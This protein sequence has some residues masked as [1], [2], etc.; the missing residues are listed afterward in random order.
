MVYPPHVAAQEWE[1]L[2]AK[3]R[4]IPSFENF[5]QPNKFIQLRKAADL[6]MLI[7]VNISNRRC[8][9]LLVD[10]D[11]KLDLIPLPPTISSSSLRRRAEAPNVYVGSGYVGGVKWKRKG[12][13]SKPEDGFKRPPRSP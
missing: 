13:A 6:S 3:A 8:D 4:A 9:A 1:D 10:S 5:L 7:I 2:L 12:K 11:G